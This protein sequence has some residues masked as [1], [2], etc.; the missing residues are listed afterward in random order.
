MIG[1]AQVLE[2]VQKESEMLKSELGTIIPMVYDQVSNLENLLMSIER[3]SNQLSNKRMVKLQ[4]KANDFVIKRF[5]KSTRNS[6]VRKTPT[7]GTNNCND[8]FDGISAISPMRASIAFKK[9]YGMNSN[10]S[11]SALTDALEQGIFPPFPCLS[12]SYN[13]QQPK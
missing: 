1:M 6:S 2:N 3:A 4:T 12:T 13:I 11:V 8:N 10:H 5:R 7:A 9:N